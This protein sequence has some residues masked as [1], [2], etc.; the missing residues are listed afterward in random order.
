M[1]F[2]N[3]CEE[4]GDAVK[5]GSE[6]YKDAEYNKCYLLCGKCFL[7]YFT[8]EQIGSLRLAIERINNEKLIAIADS[9]L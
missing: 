7:E 6:F 3:A 5:Y 1:E 2:V 9:N 4:C 8:D